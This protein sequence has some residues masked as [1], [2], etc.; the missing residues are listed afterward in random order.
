M[1]DHPFSARVP[2]RVLDLS[3]LLALGFV[4]IWATEATGGLLPGIPSIVW[5]TA[6]ALAAGHTPWVRRLRGAMHLGSL[7]VSQ[8]PALQI[9]TEIPLDPERNTVADRGLILGLCE[10]GLET[11]EPMVRQALTRPAPVV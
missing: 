6:L 3:A 7:G 5:L 1:A 4:L 8:D 2:L 11:S 9:G 10:E